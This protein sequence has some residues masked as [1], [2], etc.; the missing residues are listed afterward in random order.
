MF[1][2][3]YTKVKADVDILRFIIRSP[4]H[5]TVFEEQLTK[6]FGRVKWPSTVCST[7]EVFC[8]LDKGDP[9]AA[10]VGATWKHD[11]EQHWEHM[12]AQFAKERVET[13]DEIFAELNTKAAEL[14][15]KVGPNCMVGIS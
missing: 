3:P 4:P 5:K 6:L 13:V 9:G 8:T 12:I 1:V 15:K 14:S 10:H 11:I 2:P 7:V